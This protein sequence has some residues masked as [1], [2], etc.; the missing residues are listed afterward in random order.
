MKS[1]AR[2]AIGDNVHGEYYS[3]PYSRYSHGST[4]AYRDRT[5]IVYRDCSA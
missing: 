5:G 1:I 3:H 2:L 4:L